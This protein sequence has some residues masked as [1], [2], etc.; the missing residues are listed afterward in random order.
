MPMENGSPAIPMFTLNWN[1]SSANFEDLISGSRFALDGSHIEGPA[2]R[3]IS[4]FPH[5]LRDG[6]LYVDLSE[7][8]PGAA[9]W[10]S[11]FPFS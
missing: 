5:E 11:F 2:M 6:N 4:R 9:T 3:D 1:P 7:P 8:A 10:L